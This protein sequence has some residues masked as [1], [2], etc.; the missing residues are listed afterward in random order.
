M[1]TENIT[2]G[3]I[4]D[5]EAIVFKE[6]KR[7]LFLGLPFTFTKYTITPSLVTV[8]QGLLNTVE[9]D[10]YMYKIMD[11]KLNTSIFERIVGLKTVVCYTGDV[12]HPEIHLSHIRHAR[13]IKDYILRQSEV[14][15]VKRRTLNTVD[16]GLPGADLDGD[17]TIDTYEQ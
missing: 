12:T 3:T 13:E 11:V 10:C 15:R 2:N 9:D 14:A 17:G 1:T 8:D 6:R 5:D 7:W 16:I 4:E